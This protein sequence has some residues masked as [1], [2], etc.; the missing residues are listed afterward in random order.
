MLQV[1]LWAQSLSCQERRCLPRFRP[2]LCGACLPLHFWAQWQGCQCVFVH[3]N[4]RLT[5][6][7][8][9]SSIVLRYDG[10]VGHLGSGGM[11]MR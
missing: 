3:E 11:T 6:Q 4:Q 7:E 9:H 2:L 5:L 1:A 8:L 10:G